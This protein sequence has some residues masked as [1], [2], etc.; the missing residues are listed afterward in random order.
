MDSGTMRN[1]NAETTPDLAA[2]TND[3]ATLKRDLAALIEDMK[4]YVSGDVACA[5]SAV[6]QF[7]DETLRVYENL[8]ARGERSVKALGHRVEEHP[9]TSLLIA[10]AAGVIGS[11]MLSRRRS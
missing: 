5:R 10:F 7:R 4:G 6:G 1:P 9:V 2:I 11:R 3:I 8:T